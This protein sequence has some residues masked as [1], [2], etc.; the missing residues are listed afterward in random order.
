MNIQKQVYCEIWNWGIALFLCL[1]KNKVVIKFDQFQKPISEHLNDVTRR[2]GRH[3]LTKA[4]KC[5]T[6]TTKNCLLSSD[7][8]YEF[9]KL[10]QMVD[11]LLNCFY[12]AMHPSQY[13]SNSC[14][15]GSFI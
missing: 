2:G 7:V 8:I 11:I 14:F 1:L 9:M 4:N 5:E 3:S 10:I 6:E 12:Y 15:C 13:K